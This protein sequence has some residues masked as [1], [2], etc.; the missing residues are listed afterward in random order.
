MTHT[1]LGPCG[2]RLAEARNVGPECDDA[3]PDIG[4]CAPDEDSVASVVGLA[5]WSRYGYHRG[6]HMGSDPVAAGFQSQLASSCSMDREGQELG[7]ARL[8]R[9]LGLLLPTERREVLQ[10]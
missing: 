2:S 3:V 4:E 1:N 9:V 7:H 10:H 8:G 6:A 5:G